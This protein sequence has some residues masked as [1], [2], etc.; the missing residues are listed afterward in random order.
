MLTPLG[1]A[2]CILNSVSGNFAGG[3]NKEDKISGTA[4]LSYKPADDCSPMRAIRVAIRGRV[5]PRPRGLN[6]SAARLKQLRFK[7]ETNDAFEV[8]RK[9]NGRGIDV[10]VA[11]FHQ[12]FS[13]FQLNTFNGV[14]FVVENINSCS[15]ELERR[16]YGQQSVTGA[17]H[18]ASLR[19]PAWSS[20]G[21][22]LEA[23]T[24]PLRDLR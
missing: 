7:P 2:P 16:R 21:F 14:N 10:N 19:G 12:V 3:R 11:V 18:R 23:F 24:R 8:G 17:L 20:Q 13:N 6:P 22:E 1:A 9:Y 4:V 5:Q 15:D